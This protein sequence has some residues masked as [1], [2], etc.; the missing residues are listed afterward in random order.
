MGMGLLWKHALRSILLPIYNILDG[1]KYIRQFAADYIYTR[2]EHADYFVTSVLAIVNTVGGVIAMFYYQLKFNNLP[3]WLIFA[4]Y[5]SWVGVG[6]R[7]MGAAY[8]LAH[9]EGHFMMLYKKWIRDTVGNVFENILGV[10]FGN[11][12]WNF[13]TSHIFIHHRLDGGCGDTFYLWDFDRTSLSNFMLY[14]TRIFAHMTGYS[15]LKFFHAHGHKAKYDLL[16]KG[17]LTYWVTAVVILAITRSF[18]FVFWMYVQPLICMSYFLALINIGYHGFLEFDEKGVS[19]PCVNATCIIEGDDDYFGEDDHM[20]HHY[21]T[22]VYFRDLP[23]HQATKEQEFKQYHGSVF[24]RLSVVELSIFILLGLWD[25]IAEHYVDYSGKLTPKEI[26]SMLKIRARRTETTFE[27]YENYLC[28]PTPEARKALVQSLDTN[29][30]SCYARGAG[31][32]VVDV[33]KEQ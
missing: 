16:M 31:I 19:I 29:N 2:P 8:T 21:N 9:K 7:I 24:R 18:Y 30:D 28:N 23:A 4:Y 14:V 15:S 12:P 10:W 22:N 33:K 17:V 32:S 20:S 27:E 13:T 5:C 25:K 11:V 1:N 26:V 3:A 6:G